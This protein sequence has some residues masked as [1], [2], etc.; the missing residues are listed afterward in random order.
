[1]ALDLVI[2]NGTVVTAEG[3]FPAD[4]AIEEGIIVGLGKRGAFSGAKKEID[5]EGKLLLP[6]AIDTHTH[7]EE[8]FQGLVPDEDW[9][10]GTRN[11]AIGGVTTVLNFVIQEKGRAL[12]DCIRGEMKRIAELA[13]VDF[14]FH[15]V[16]TELGDMDVVKREIGEL[17]A[18]GVTSLKAFMIYT[19]GGLYTDDWA[20]YNILQEV[21]KYG[22][23]LGVH[24]ENMSIGE[25]MQKMMAREGRVQAKDW[26]FAKPYFVEV[27]AV[28]RA[29]LLAEATGSNLYIVHMSAKE[30]VEV[31]N[32]YRKK[33]L[34][35]FSETCPHYMVFTEDIYSQPGVG[36]WQIISPPLRKKE[37][38]EAL[39]QGI[40]NGAVSI[41][42][43]DHNAYQKGPKDKGYAEKGFLGVSNGGPGIIEGLPVMYSEG[44]R[45][46]R[47][48][49]E[50]MVEVT[51]TNPAKMFGLYPQKGTIAPG[52]D[53][54]IVIFDPQ[55]KQKLGYQLYDSM[56][57]TVYEGME[58]QGFPAATILRGKVIVDNGQFLGHKGDGQFIFGK[59]DKRIVKTIR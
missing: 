59:M 45:T 27:E 56:D 7:I 12:M 16:F 51:S 52:S 36:V 17:F 20:L 58:V 24:A 46:G 26:P 39:W 37:D 43:S 25:N 2:K 22:G 30:A 34:S 13:C 47:I 11:A 44:V 54:D 50:R 48:T 28:Q 55:K 40:A 38:N 6:G 49:Q 8:P 31:V 4:V 15:G 21:K 1:M 42:G 23:F 14:N 53:A 32:S 29:C 5:A 9:T 33:G 18:A 57:W 19:D 41:I 3:S 10:A 35:I